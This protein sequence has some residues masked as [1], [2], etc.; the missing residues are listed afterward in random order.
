[1]SD[2]EQHHGPPSVDPA[3]VKIIVWALYAACAIVVVLDLDYEKEVHFGVE[4][5]LGFHAV[6]GFVAYVSLVLLATQLRKLI[7]RDEEYYDRD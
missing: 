2:D 5:Y 4:S 3:R 7:M 6:F 1:M